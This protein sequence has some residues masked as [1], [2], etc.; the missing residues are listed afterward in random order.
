MPKQL[1]DKNWELLKSKFKSRASVWVHL[2]SVTIIS[3]NRIA[4]FKNC[5]KQKVK[6]LL[7]RIVKN[8]TF[9]IFKLRW[10]KW[11]EGQKSSQWK[12]DRCY[13]PWGRRFWG[14]EKGDITTKIDKIISNLFTKVAR[15]VRS[16]YIVNAIK[17]FN[18]LY[19]RPT[20]LIRLV[21][22]I[23]SAI[24]DQMINDYMIPLWEGR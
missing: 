24:H 20:F 10:N 11:G 4:N 16:Q 6:Y 7:I 15:V 9:T 17:H 13:L 1:L 22:K 21:K 19:H 23:Y 12:S 8:S 2:R 14:H 18:E 3:N 5:T